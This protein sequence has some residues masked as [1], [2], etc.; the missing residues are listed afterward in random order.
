MIL[1]LVF[2]D[3]LFLVQVKCPESQV[4][5]YV[6]KLNEHRCMSYGNYIQFGR[7]AMLY[8]LAYL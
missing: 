2:L 4:R 6:L 8:N 1:Y 3:I 5:Y 7:V